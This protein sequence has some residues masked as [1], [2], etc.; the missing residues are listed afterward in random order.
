MGNGFYLVFGDDL[1]I[2]CGDIHYSIPF[3]NQY[4]NT[5]SID[6]RFI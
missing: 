5:G 4:L 6:V 1:F 2:Y 3:S